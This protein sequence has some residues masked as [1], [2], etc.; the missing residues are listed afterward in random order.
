M[1]TKD[2]GGKIPGVPT[3][4]TATLASGTSANVVFTAPAYTGKGTLT[5]RAT[6]DSGQTN[7]GASSPIVVSGMTAGT[8]RTFTVV[9]ISSNGVESAASSSSP[10][11]V[12]GVAPSAPT[13]GSASAGNA[14]ATVTWTQ[15]ATGTAGAGDITYRVTSS[16]S[17]VVATGVN[18]SSIVVTG[19]TNGTAYTFVVRAESTY[20]NSADSAATNSV[21]P[22]APPHF[23]PHFPPFFPPFFP[24]YFPPHFPPLFK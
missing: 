15:G 12:M 14:Q 16:P 18:I 24:P 8:T 21:T 20:G 13:I 17:S 9:A 23:P 7:T 5:Y 19:L 11:L 1:A 10:S 4:G 22:V 6:S 2:S 3:I